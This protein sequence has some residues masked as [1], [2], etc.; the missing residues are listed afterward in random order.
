M[1]T[2]YCAVYIPRWHRD[3]IV[4]RCHRYFSPLA[5]DTD[6]HLFVSRDFDLE[7]ENSRIITPDILLRPTDP[8]LSPTNAP[9]GKTDLV[10][11]E[12][13]KNTVFRVVARK[14]KQTDFSFS[15]RHFVG[16]QTFHSSGNKPDRVRLGWSNW[17]VRFVDNLCCGVLL[18]IRHQDYL[19]RDEV[20]S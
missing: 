17:L 11:L 7:R 2:V 9:G 13:T 10:G 4:C 1:L 6:A 12:L 18:S 19:R 15:T 3:C 14:W 16:D 5:T 8:S 20:I